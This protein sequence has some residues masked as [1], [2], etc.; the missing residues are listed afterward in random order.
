MR[1]G[2]LVALLATS[3]VGCSGGGQPA[4]T[5][6]RTPPSTT[7]TTSSST[8]T[9]TTSTWSPQARQEWSRQLQ[10]AFGEV[11]DALTLMTNAM[12]AGDFKG[13]HEG[14]EQ[15]GQAGRQMDALLPGY[16][17]RLTAS[18]RASAKDIAAAYATCQGFKPGITQAQ[19]KRFLDT[20]SQVTS[21]VGE[22]TGGN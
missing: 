1:T 13:V 19:A 3:V 5:S 6:F 17:H 4:V 15:L 2:P 18:V 14:C 12:V 16:D 9:S 8:V 22:L 10:A 7:T 11:D 21:R 20:L